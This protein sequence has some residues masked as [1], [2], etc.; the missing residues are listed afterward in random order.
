MLPM[1]MALL[2]PRLKEFFERNGK[3]DA[4]LIASVFGGMIPSHPTV[5]MGLN[6]LGQ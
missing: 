4:L 3:C 5:G 2:M 1:S 6:C